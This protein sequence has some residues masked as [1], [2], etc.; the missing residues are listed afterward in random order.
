ML[1]SLIYV[2]R[3]LTTNKA[4]VGST[5]KGKRRPLGHIRMLNKGVH[6]NPYL[7][8]A[9][10]KYGPDDFVWHVVEICE[11]EEL[12]AREQWWIGFLRTT[13][14][15][16]GYNLIYPVADYRQAIKSQ[17]AKTQ[18]EKWRDPEI[19]SKRLT[20]L[21]VL[22]KDPAWKARRAATMTAK[23]ADPDWRA[24]MLKVLAN[25]VDTLNNRMVN[26]PGF[27]EHRMRGIQPNSITR[28]V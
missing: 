13:D 16:Y 12:L 27:K 4:Y 8:A 9:W 28:R 11:P 20:G 21:K 6:D 22:H 5:I 18:I 7:Q 2:G 10:N 25:N 26:E 14:E 17:L 23:W 24:K 3:N 1:K 15:R 19:R